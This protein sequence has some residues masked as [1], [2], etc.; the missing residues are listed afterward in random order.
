[1]IIGDAIVRVARTYLYIRE[2]TN[3]ND[4]PM[5]DKMLDYQGLPHHLSWCLAF[6]VWCA[7]V[8]VNPL[9]YPKMARCSL[10]LET[11]ESQPWKYDM[12]DADDVAW[13]INK[14]TPGTI[15]IFSSGKVAGNDNWNG[16]A[17]MVEH[18]GK[19]VI[20]VTEAEHHFKWSDDRRT[21]YTIEGNTNGAGSREGNG[22]YRKI[23]T[24]K[25]GALLL[26]GF[27]VR[28]EKI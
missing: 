4:H 12:F 19:K 3:H 28:K 20:V 14:V 15:M 24:A 10:F 8:A 7:H 25:Q 26:E 5:I 21:W 9:P 2:R 11:V 6:V 16:H 17:A 13:G 27:I 18:V 23:R 22:V 1:M